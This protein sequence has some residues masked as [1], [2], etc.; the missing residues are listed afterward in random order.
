M[1]QNGMLQDSLFQ[2]KVGQP[3]SSMIQE[4]KIKNPNELLYYIKI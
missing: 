4:S 1:T 2:I 3:G